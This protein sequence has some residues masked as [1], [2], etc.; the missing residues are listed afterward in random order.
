[1]FTFLIAGAV[2]LGIAAI[3]IGV[4]ALRKSANRPQ[5]KLQPLPL[6]N[7]PKK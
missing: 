5:I 2:V 1:M 6:K 3:W 4:G 7:L